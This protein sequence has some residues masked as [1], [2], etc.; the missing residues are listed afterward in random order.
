MAKT[1]RMLSSRRSGRE[2]SKTKALVQSRAASEGSGRGVLLAASRTWPPRWSLGLRVTP[3][4]LASR[5][6]RVHMAVGFT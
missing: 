5:G 6:R 4:R 2:Q 3:S 1:N